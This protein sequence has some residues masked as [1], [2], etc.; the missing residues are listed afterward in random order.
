MKP[1]ASSFVGPNRDQRQQL[2]ACGAGEGSHCRVR[3]L[4]KLVALGISA[5]RTEEN[6]SIHFAG[7]ANGEFENL[8]FGERR[9]SGG[10]TSE[11][12]P[13]TANRKVLC[14][15]CC[16][17]SN[18]QRLNGK[19]AAKATHTRFGLVPLARSHRSWF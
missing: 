11:V 18:R 17:G 1:P 12:P 8:R 13:R 10:R 3:P 15:C 4:V 5:G 16:F 19:S 14:C 9:R 6:E 7:L 2:Q